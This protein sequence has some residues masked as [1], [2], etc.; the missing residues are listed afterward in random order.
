MN[1]TRLWRAEPGT[2]NPEQADV[3]CRFRPSTPKLPQPFAAKS[4]ATATLK[5]DTR[6]NI[7]RKR[8]LPALFSL[9]SLLQPCAGLNR[10]GTKSFLEREARGQRGSGE[11]PRKGMKPVRFR[12]HIHFY[13]R[14]YPLISAYIRSYPQL[15]AN[16]RK[17]PHSDPGPETKHGGMPP[18]ARLARHGSTLLDLLRPRSPQFT[19]V[20]ASS[21]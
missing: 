8:T 21:P 3:Q 12:P 11:S 4:W 5:I 17:Y 15:S 14:L 10:V 19:L 7:R 16:I 6:P 13:S 18:P 1:F 20:H 9:V 2:R